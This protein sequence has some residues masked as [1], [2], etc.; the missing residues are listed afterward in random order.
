MILGTFTLCLPGT[1]VSIKS[2]LTYFPYLEKI[3]E[4]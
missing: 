1:G 3:K 2:I 4:G